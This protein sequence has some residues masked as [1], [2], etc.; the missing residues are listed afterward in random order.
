[1]GCKYIYRKPN[2]KLLQGVHTHSFPFHM[3]RRVDAAAAIHKSGKETMHGGHD[4][5]RGV[6]R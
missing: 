4:I 5:V 6:M 2:C 3:E 1:M